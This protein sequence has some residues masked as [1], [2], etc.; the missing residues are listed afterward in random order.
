[1]KGYGRINRAYRWLRR[2][3]IPGAIILMYHRVFNPVSDPFEMC[4]SPVLFKQQME[5]IRRKFVPMRLLDLAAGMESGKLPQRAVVVTFDDGYIDNIEIAYPILK[6]FD[7]PATVFIPSDFIGCDREF[8]WDE[9]ERI[10]YTPQELP[11]EL[12]LVVRGKEYR[13][14]TRNQADRQKALF[15]MQSILKPLPSNERYRTL[16]ALISWSNTS[17]QQRPEY[18]TMTINELLILQED[19]LI[20]FGAHTATHPSLAQLSPELQRTEIIKGRER[21]EVAL[22][23]SINVFAYPYG[24]GIDI[25]QETADIVKKAGYKLACTTIPGGIEYRDDPFWLRRCGIH[26]WEFQTFE[27]N[28]HAFYIS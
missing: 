24:K 13:L 9:L 17:R 14:P 19:G 20:D 7:I 10:L 21:L 25:S 2:R 27:R 28:L 11:N 23:K 8:W 22:G 18:R 1:M 15:S 26:N 4:V 6:Q 5:Y 3:V 12:R 16:D